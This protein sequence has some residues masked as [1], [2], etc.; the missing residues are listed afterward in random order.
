MA[1]L[2]PSTAPDWLFRAT[3]KL[4]KS[5]FRTAEFKYKTIIKDYEARIQQYEKFTKDAQ[6]DISRLETELF[7]QL[8]LVSVL[9]GK[10]AI[11]TKPEVA[12]KDVQTEIFKVKSIMEKETA[13]MQKK[14][15]N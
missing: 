11:Y 13:E 5:I 15:K 3:T 14:E 10:L 1:S 6:A 9:E 2:S 8:E 4:Q 7:E 12:V